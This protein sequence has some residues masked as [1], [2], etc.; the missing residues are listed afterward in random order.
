MLPLYLNDIEKIQITPKDKKT[1][2]TPDAFTFITLYEGAK[3]AMELF[4]SNSISIKLHVFDVT[5]EVSTAEQLIHNKALDSIDLIIGPVYL[6]PF[7]LMSDYAKQR[8]IFIINPLSEKNEILGNNPFVIKIQPSDKTILQTLLQQIDLKDTLQRILILSDHHNPQEAEYLQQVQPFFEALSSPMKPVFIDISKDKTEQIQPQLSATKK[9]IILYLST[10]EAI[11]TEILT[12]FSKL[13]KMSIAL[14]CLHNLKQFEFIEPQ[15]L[16]NLRMH[17]AEPFF[18][19]PS[20]P[21]E[22]DFEYRFF[23]T[24]QT[25][26]DKNAYLGFDITTYAL[27]LL[28]IGNTNYGNFLESYKYK[29]FH[30]TIQLRRS[31]ASNGFENQSVN[32][33]KTENSQLKKA[34]E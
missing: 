27:Q 31:G 24:Y 9:N 17:Y 2:K 10:N 25:I 22:A 28:K 4:D 26:P 3:L 15:Y 33:L 19:D 18:V 32:I 23:N 7:K 21:A 1:K 30:N 5:N 16:H 13:D 14:Y 29:G 6:H 34:N 12:Q 8:G 20:L 11:I